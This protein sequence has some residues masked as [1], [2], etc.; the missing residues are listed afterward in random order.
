MGG[1][2]PKI[3]MKRI[4]DIGLKLEPLEFYTV[5]RK[6]GTQKHGGMGLGLERL[7]SLITFAGSVRDCVAYPR[8][9]QSK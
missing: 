7:V 8:F 2:G 6:Y 4:E 5:L 1:V 3:L 9:Y